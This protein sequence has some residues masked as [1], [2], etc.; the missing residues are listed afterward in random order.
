M[1]VES[2][3]DRLSFLSDWDSALYKGTNTISCI[4]DAEYVD[5]FSDAGVESNAPA[6]IC[7]TSDVSDAAH[8]FD[9][10]INA[11]SYKIRGVKPT[12][13]GMTLLKLEAV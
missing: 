11:V 2:A 1:A 5:V 3:A 6:A 9:M 12:G 7:R 13:D 10:V 8:G 4:F